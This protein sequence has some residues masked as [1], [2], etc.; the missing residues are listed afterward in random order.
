MPGVSDTGRSQFDDVTHDNTPTIFLRL[1]DGILSNDLP[2]NAASMPGTSPPNGVPIPIPFNPSTAASPVNLTAGYRVAVYDETDTQ[3]PVFLGFAQSVANLN[4]VYSFT[5]V[6][7]LL[8]GS[9][10]ISARVQIIDPADNDAVP[11]TGRRRN[12]DSGRGAF[13]WRLSSIPL[14]R[15]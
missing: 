6:T 5:F 15:R 9:H 3:N 7:P 11:G 14:H 10:F 13:R 4:G 8:D 2:G 1:D 12:R